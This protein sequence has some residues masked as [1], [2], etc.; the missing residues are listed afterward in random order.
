MNDNNLAAFALA[1]LTAVAALAQPCAYVTNS[2]DDTISVIDT[3]TNEVT[4]TVGSESWREATYGAVNRDGRFFYLTIN[5]GRT[6]DVGCPAGSN[7]CQ[8]KTK[9][10]TSKSKVRPDSFFR[11]RHR[12]S[13]GALFRRSRSPGRL[14]RKESLMPT[15]IP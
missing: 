9:Y 10:K 6:F 11:L 14:S 13:F 3:A 8:S 1:Q 15:T 12:K 2:L 7:P 5:G 4:A